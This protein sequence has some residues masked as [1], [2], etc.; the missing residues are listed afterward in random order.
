MLRHRVG[1]APNLRQQSC[2]ASGDH[3]ASSPALLEERKPAVVEGERCESEVRVRSRLL[4]EC[5]K[6]THRCRDTMTLCI[7][8]TFQ[9][10]SHSSLGTS[11]PPLDGMPLFSICARRARYVQACVRVCVSPWV[12]RLEV[13]ERGGKRRAL[14]AHH[15]LSACNASRMKAPLHQLTRYS[16]K[17]QWDRGETRC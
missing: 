9:M 14:G 13:A 1:Q 5:I 12:R 16:K 6:N 17:R 3:E 8:F 2:R 4:R 15:V 11:G 7:T 10:R